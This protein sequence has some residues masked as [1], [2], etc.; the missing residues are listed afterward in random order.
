MR[1]GGMRPEPTCLL[2]ALEV[3]RRGGILAFPTDTLYG[4]TCDPRNAG[5]LSALYRLKR[6]SESL[7]IPFIACDPAQAGQL[8]SLEGAMAQL[9]AKNF[10]PGPLTLV[11]PLTGRDRLADREWGDSLAIRVPAAPWARALAK[12]A[13]V[14]LPAT[15][16]NLSGGSPVSDPGRLPEEVAQ[17][18]DLLLDAGRLPASLAST[19]LDLTGPAPKLLRDGA[20]SVDAITRIVA[21]V[22]LPQIGQ[23]SVT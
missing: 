10:W 1:V 18:I 22:P 15:S 2:Q 11:L 20:V 13:G 9:L 19:I 23:R 17:D 12:A 5:A 14:P 6:R 21:Q 7:R 4:L 16:A 3:L 8:V